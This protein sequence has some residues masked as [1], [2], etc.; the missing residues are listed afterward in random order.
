MHS[1]LGKELVLRRDLV[2]SVINFSFI[3]IVR[4]I[5]K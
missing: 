5:I 4:V 3:S 1:C 2:E